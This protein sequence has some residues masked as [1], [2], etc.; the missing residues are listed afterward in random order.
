MTTTRTATAVTGTEHVLRAAPAELSRL[1]RPSSPLRRK[2]PARKALGP[3]G[4]EKPAAGTFPVGAHDAGKSCSE[5]NFKNSDG[6]QENGHVMLS[7]QSQD[8]KPCG[9]RNPDVKSSYR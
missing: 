1:Q 3:A 5:T 9:N 6:R 4:K 8:M 2:E 7:E